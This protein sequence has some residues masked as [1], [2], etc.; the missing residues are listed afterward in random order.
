MIPVLFA[1]LAVVGVG[2]LYWMNRRHGSL[3][4]FRDWVKN[5]AYGEAVEAAFAKEDKELEQLTVPADMPGKDIQALVERLLEV[6]TDRFTTRRLQLLG[7]RAVPAL[8]AALNDPRFLRDKKTD[9]WVERLPLEKVLDLLEPFAPP[10]A[11]PS[12]ALLMKNKDAKFRKIAA[13]ALGNIGSNAC[14]EPVTAALADEDDY[15]RSYALMGI[16]RGLKAGHSMPRFL[17]AIFERIVPLLERSD[18]SVDGG[19]PV[20]LLQIDRAKAIPVLGGDRYFTAENR[21]LHCILKALNEAAISIPVEKLKT[22]MEAL[23]PKAKDYPFDCSYGEALIALARSGDTSA[24]KVIR[25]A[26]QV[27]NERISEDAAKALCLINGIPNPKKFVYG[28]VQEVGFAGLTQPQQA[29]YAISILDGEVRNGGFSQYFVN[30]SGNQA[31]EA[32]RGLELVGAKQTLGIVRQAFQQFGPNG[33]PRDRQQRARQLAALTKAQDAALD[34]L[35]SEYYKSEERLEV[36][37]LL[38]AI[39]N[40]DHFR[41]QPGPQVQP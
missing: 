26:L 38:F 23:Q 29:I 4:G 6:E 15:V 1:V 20:T 5:S 34:R 31:S 33:P 9:S 2:M 35:N 25:A 22:V 21:E 41:T 13:L 16:Q 12:L 36:K 8:L 19:A 3:G 37:M 11:V 14:I 10:E 17:E 30:S 32:L 39:A 28:R 24:E 7:D 27:E 40:K 18:S